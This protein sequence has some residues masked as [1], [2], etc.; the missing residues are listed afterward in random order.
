[1]MAMLDI[2]QL[3]EMKLGDVLKNMSDMGAGMAKVT[4]SDSND[5]PLLSVVLIT[6]EDIGEY[7]SVIDSTEKKLEEDTVEDAVERLRQAIQD[8]EGFGRVFCRQKLHAPF[9]VTGVMLDS[10]GEIIIVEE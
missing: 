8:C 3:A 10:A 7:L 2:N 6:G 5:N 9:Q 1:M 4:M